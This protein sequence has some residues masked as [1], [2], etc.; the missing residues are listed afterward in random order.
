M[1]SQDKVLGVVSDVP[2]ISQLKV[3]EPGLE[4]GCSV[5]RHAH[6]ASGTRMQ[7]PVCIHT[8]PGP[9]LDFINWS[10]SRESEKNLFKPSI[11]GKRDGVRPIQTLSME[12][13]GFNK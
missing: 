7:C 3:A 11:A 12:C 9:V 8:V 10:A 4:L 6:M 1:A 5:L 13:K 2:Q